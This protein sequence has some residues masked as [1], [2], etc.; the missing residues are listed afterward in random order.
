MSNHVDIEML[1][2][3]KGTVRRVDG[4]Q[5]IVISYE[6]WRLIKR[7]GRL[8]KKLEDQQKAARREVQ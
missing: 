6:V 5:R 4:E 1:L 7:V 3:L 8:A 2:R